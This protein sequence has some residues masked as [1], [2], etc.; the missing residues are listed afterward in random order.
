M[1]REAVQSGVDAESDR[2]NITGITNMKRQASGVRG[3]GVSEFVFTPF[4][5]RLTPNEV[6]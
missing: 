3:K 4:V 5:L 6:V 1:D 2:K